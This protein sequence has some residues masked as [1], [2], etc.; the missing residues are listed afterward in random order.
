M[1]I[2]RLKLNNVCQHKVKD[3][4]FSPGLNAIV[5]LNGTGK[6]NLIKAMYAVI[7]ND[8]SRFVGIKTDQISQYALAKDSSSIELEFEHGPNL[9]K[10]F[11]GLR[12]TNKYLTIN[13][14]PKITK[15]NEII[16]ELGGILGVSHKI[17]SDYVFVDQWQLFSFIDQKSSE[18]SKAFQQLF[19]TEKAELC[20]K[21]LGDEIGKLN[22]PITICVD[23]DTPRQHLLKNKKE[24]QLIEVT[25]NKLISQLPENT[26]TW[27]KH[28][29]AVIKKYDRRL[30]LLQQLKHYRNQYV[31]LVE[32]KT[33][34]KNELVCLENVIEKHKPRV[35]KTEETCNSIRQQI[36]EWEKH[37]GT[38]RKQGQL[39]I[40][41]RQV[42]QELD[43]LTD[44]QDEA[45]ELKNLQQSIN[46]TK[47]QHCL[48]INEVNRLEKIITTLTGDELTE[49][50]TCGSPLSKLKLETYGHDCNEAKNQVAQL[51]AELIGYQ[52][53]KAEI[54]S[55]KTR[56]VALLSRRDN[57]QQQ[58]ALLNSVA[59]SD[60]PTQDQITQLTTLEQWLQQYI[61]NL[62]RLNEVRQAFSSIEGRVDQLNEAITQ[63]DAEWRAINITAED[64]K[65]AEQNLKELQ[66]QLLTKAGLT[67]KRE[68]LKKLIEED[69]QALRDIKKAKERLA[70]TKYTINVLEQMR[71]ILHRDNLP[72][73]VAQYYLNQLEDNINS[74]L[75]SFDSP[76]TISPTDDLS[77]MASFQDGRNV[78]VEALS[79][80]EKALFA[81]AFRIVINST[82][83]HD[84]GL[85]C[86]DEPTAGLDEKNIGCLT[87][88]LDKLRQLSK[89]TGL[90]CILITHEKSLMPH[91]DKVIEL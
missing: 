45:K 80:G 26:D 16:N 39:K 79:G 17:L 34:V 83:A 59:V 72:K 77:F 42:L 49:C 90:Q 2:K 54:Q 81:I 56:R 40:E 29:N 69:R 43:E 33:L 36:A 15:E 7:T 53:L 23:E 91:F 5:G 89:A 32:Q 73:I 37:K 84:I 87:I 18:R 58:I 11:R 48:M 86:L 22:S 38:K 82:F 44:Y 61:E 14:G 63:I 3:T 70:Q 78:K 57:L 47:D 24:L 25:L 68:A 9:L 62:E 27:C 66:E 71:D 55:R 10:I 52:Q 19:G 30:K 1:R 20:W 75:D 65:Q 41:L 60:K 28:Q 50:P 74:V 67:V 35:K 21:L 4:T 8:F 51:A 6:S 13:N 64:A 46:Q 76:F 12:P 31:K 85:L 88:A